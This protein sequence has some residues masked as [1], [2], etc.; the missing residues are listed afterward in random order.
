MH[1][2]GRGDRCGD[3][4]GSLGRSPPPTRHDVHSAA[5]ADPCGTART[6]LRSGCSAIPCTRSSG[7][8]RPCTGEADP[9]LS[10]E[11]GAVRLRCRAAFCDGC[12]SSRERA[13]SGRTE[14]TGML[15]VRR[16]ASPCRPPSSRPVRAWVAGAGR[17]PRKVG[18]QSA[19]GRL[20][21][22]AQLATSGERRLA[23][24]WTVADRVTYGLHRRGEHGQQWC[25]SNTGSTRYGDTAPRMGSLV[26]MPGA[27][28]PLPSSTGLQGAASC[29]GPVVPTAR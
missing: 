15:S 24:R 6:Q 25:L 5:H 17:K 9:P 11:N 3:P 8:L 21:G 28:A 22:S 18:P 23:S 10:H 7:R 4:R 13:R 19:L 2:F 20:H 14:G 29:Q 1:G 27:V 16:R 26:R 12:C